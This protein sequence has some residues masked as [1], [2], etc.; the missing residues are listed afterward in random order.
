[1]NFSP[2]LCAIPSEVADALPKVSMLGTEEGTYAVARLIM[3][4]VDWIFNLFGLSHHP[5]LELW[6]YSALVFAISWGIGW[7]TQIIVLFIVDQI[8]K[9]WKGSIYEE[10]IK[11]KFFHKISRIIPAIIFL[12]FI[13]FTMQEHSQLSN[14][15]SRLTWISLLDTSPSPRDEEACR[16]A[17]S[18]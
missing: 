8:G 2:F 9:R 1:M 17:S 18:A 5:T 10:L 3:N 7:I 13:Q 15:L 14:W 16:L 4:I 11:A 12:I 6:I